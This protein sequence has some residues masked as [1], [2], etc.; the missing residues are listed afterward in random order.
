MNKF[1]KYQTGFLGGLIGGLV[2][3]AL[4]LGG[5]DDYLT[6]D[7]IVVDEVKKVDNVSIKAFP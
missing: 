7:G 5:N 1:K 6:G 2:G 4:G 3:G